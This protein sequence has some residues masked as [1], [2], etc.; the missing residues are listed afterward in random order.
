LDK[1]SCLPEPCN[2]RVLSRRYLPLLETF[3]LWCS[4]LLKCFVDLHLSV[5]LTTFSPSGERASP[6]GLYCL[7]LPSDISYLTFPLKFRLF[8][9]NGIRGPF[10]FLVFVLSQSKYRNFSPLLRPFF[11][12]SRKF[13]FFPSYPCSHET[14]PPKICCDVTPPAFPTRFFFLFFFV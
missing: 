9:M 11:Q 12:P 2:P 8:L 3:L 13:F 5:F 14:V 7:L 4:R 6:P 10:F 1:L